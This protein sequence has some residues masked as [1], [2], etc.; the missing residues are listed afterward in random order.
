MNIAYEDDKLSGGGHG[1][2]IFTEIPPACK[3]ASFAIMRASDHQ[4]AAGKSKMWVGEKVFLPISQKP[5]PDGRL[6]VAIG[7][8][9]VDSLDIRET[10]AVYLKDQNGAEQRGRL[11]IKQIAYS[12]A[13]P[14]DNTGSSREELQAEEMAPHKTSIVLEKDEAE[15]APPEPAAPPADDKIDMPEAREEKKA[16]TRVWRWIIL[17]L[18]LLG[19][20]AWFLLDPRK[21]EPAAPEKTAREEP[22]SPVKIE[23]PQK[24]PPQDDKPRIR[25]DGKEITAAEAV[26]LSRNM[27][28]ATK[29][30]QDAIYR[31][32]YFAARY[33]EPTVLLDY[34]ACLDPSKPDW[35]TIGKDAVLAYEAYSKARA[36]YPQEAQRAMQDLVR[37]LEEN[38]PRDNQAK[39]WLGD[40]SRLRGK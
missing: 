3:P 27:P 4:F 18:L 10:Y 7:P 33:D 6:Q 11:Q 23:E 16:G 31:L 26:E 32:Y 39:I 2:L 28:R 21:D 13:A 8:G 40:I 36:K 15:K 30:Q 22:K 29:A 38:A 14:L 20:V 12:P 9:L 25:F 19:C 5:G 34:G 24:Q 37:W 17:L 1:T 35:G